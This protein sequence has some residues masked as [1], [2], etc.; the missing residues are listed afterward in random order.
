MT[1]FCRTNIGEV[2]MNAKKSTFYLP[3]EE[4]E[5]RRKEAIPWHEEQIKKLEEEIRIA[6]QTFPE[7]SVILRAADK[8]SRHLKDNLY[9]WKMY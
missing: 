7:D 9:R 8:E 6:K 5:Q 3:D 1:E 4:F 2:K